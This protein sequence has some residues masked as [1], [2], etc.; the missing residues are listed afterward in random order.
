MLS[1]LKRINTI[2][3]RSMFAVSDPLLQDLDI[4]CH[5]F[6]VRTEKAPNKPEGAV[7]SACSEYF[8]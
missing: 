5:V 8:G 3:M 4:Y 6:R 2:I 7:I 1:F